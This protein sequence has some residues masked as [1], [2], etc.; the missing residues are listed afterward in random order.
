MRATL[1]LAL[2]LIVSAT[3]AGRAET[4]DPSVAGDRG[5]SNIASIGLITTLGPTGLFQNATSGIAPKYAFSVESCMGFKENNGDH[6]QANG[7]LVTYGVTDWL[8]IS[9][10]GLLVSG[11]DP[12]TT[13]DSELIAG[14]FNARARVLRETDGL[15]EV[16]VG[17]I[18]SF[19]D[20]PLVAHSLYLATSKG[21]ALSDGDFMRGIRLHA[22][23]R[24]TWPVHAQDITTAFVGLELEV[25]K[26]LYLIGEVNT[27]DDSFAKTP[28]SAGFQ[29]KS[30]SFGF[31]AAVMQAPNE[32]RETYYVGIGVSY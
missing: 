8:E 13:G 3:T 30:S 7:L 12:T 24:E 26:N 20:D 31:S 10:F 22:G 19:G 21:F 32:T 27:R 16:T 25:V 18:A 9:G 28:W 4:A 23:I 6:F 2:A 29:Y 15:P 14:S 11:L 1:G 5:Y 17:G